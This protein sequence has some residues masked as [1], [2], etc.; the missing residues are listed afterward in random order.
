MSASNTSD[1]SLGTVNWLS[2]VDNDSNSDNPKDWLGTY[3]HLQFFDPASKTWQSME[4][5][6]GTGVF[7]GA[8]DL[9]PHATVDIKMRLSLDAKAPV[10]DGFAIGL[11]GYT[12]DAKC[13]HTAYSEYDFKVLAPGKSAGNPGD[14]TGTSAP[15][16]VGKKP[17]G[18]ITDLPATGS[19]AETGASSSLPTIALSGGAAVVLGAGAMFIV[20]RRKSG[21]AA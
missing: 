2:A 15:A 4:D 8:T 16:P 3:A 7:F 18:G 9:G 6:V 14:A 11:G 13:D 1:K 5:L 19:L 21:S 17:Q 10:G 20:R 12:D